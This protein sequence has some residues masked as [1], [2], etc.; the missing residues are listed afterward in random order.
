MDAVTEKAVEQSVIDP[1]TLE[2]IRHGIISITNQID[3][4]Q[5]ITQIASSW[6]D[7]AHP[8]TLASMTYNSWGALTTL[9]DGCAVP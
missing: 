1:V 3:A 2:V 6:S 7:S 9:T 5:R 4:N 8:G